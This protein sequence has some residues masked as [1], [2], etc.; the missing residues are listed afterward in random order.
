MFVQQNN[1]VVWR[2]DERL[3]DVSKDE[4]YREGI[5][6]FCIFFFS[7]LRQA[8]KPEGLE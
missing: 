7:V 8:P 6:N 5:L 4:C 1:R 2:R 3:V